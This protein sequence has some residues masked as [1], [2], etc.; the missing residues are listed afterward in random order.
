MNHWEPVVGTGRSGDNAPP[1]SVGHANHGKGLP[2]QHV[3]SIHPARS[4]NR[5][6]GGL[7]RREARHATPD[8]GG[9][10]VLSSWN[11][12]ETLPVGS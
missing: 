8:A 3:G 6:A 11:A 12:E 7:P 5:T 4:V 2:R 10:G 9:M 1:Q